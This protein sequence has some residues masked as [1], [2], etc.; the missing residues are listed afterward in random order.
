MEDRNPAVSI[1]PF[2]LGYRSSRLAPSRYLVPSPYGIG[3]VGPGSSR[4]WTAFMTAGQGWWQALPLG[5]TGYGNSP[6]SCLSSFAG[7]GLLISPELLIED[8]LLKLDEC[9]G[10]IFAGLIDYDVVI[11]FKQ[12]MLVLAWRRFRAG[13]R[14]RPGAGSSRSS[15]RA[16]PVGW[17]ITLCTGRLKATLITL[18]TW[19]GRRNWPAANRP[20]SHSPARTSRSRSI[21]FDLAQFLLNR[22]GKRLKEYA[23]AK[24]SG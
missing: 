11:P 8:G 15:V 13:V 4:G 1:P 20:H 22:Q 10:C 16:G 2:P 5:P 24:V 9:R 18:P 17:K 23:R 3:D 21:R 12:R 6:Y 7:N 19:T 14:E